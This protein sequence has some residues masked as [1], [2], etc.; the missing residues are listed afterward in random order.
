MA[1]LVSIN[2]AAVV[3]TGSWTGSEGRTGIDKRPVEHAV[4]LAD[5]HVEGDT[6]VDRKHHGG[7][8]KAVYAYAQEDAAWWE[9]QLSRTIN[10]GAFGENLTTAGIDLNALAIGTRL[11]IGGA[12]LEV[13]EPRIPCRVFAGF[14]DLPHLV[15]DFTTAA[16]PG[17]YL[18]IIEPG[19]VAAGDAIEVLSTPEH[20]I[21]VAMAFKAKSNDLPRTEL[22]PALANFSEDWQDWITK[23]L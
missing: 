10:P 16:R 13:S 18:R 20:G 2:I 5:D 3:V 12:V 8:H 19:E 21:T 1:Q 11:Q 7:Q 15:K 9:Q 17:T 22:V 14:W 6:V 23:A 4:R